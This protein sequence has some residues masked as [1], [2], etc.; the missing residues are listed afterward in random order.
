M[1][2]GLEGLDLLYSGWNLKIKMVAGLWAIPFARTSKHDNGPHGCPV[3]WKTD[4]Y[5]QSLDKFADPPC[6]G[7]FQ[8]GRILDR[9]LSSFFD[10]TA[11]LFEL[12]RMRRAFQQHG[13]FP[14]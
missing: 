4:L 10:V 6:I 8:S 2:F 13:G 5:S 9:L 3:L 12:C 14:I 11:H 7:F 1:N